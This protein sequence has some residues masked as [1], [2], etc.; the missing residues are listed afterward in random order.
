DVRVVGGRER[1]LVTRHVFD[2]ESLAHVLD[3]AAAERDTV[4]RPDLLLR[5]VRE[6]ERADR[7]ASERGRELVGELERATTGG[8]IDGVRAI[9]GVNGLRDAGAE[10]RVRF[11]ELA[12]AGERFFLDACDGRAIRRTENPGARFAKSAADVRERPWLEAV[13]RERESGE[14]LAG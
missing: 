8:A 10:R 11:R 1:D 14:R 6:H 7:V 4:A 13:E 3:E 9:D 12:L 5:T 2:P